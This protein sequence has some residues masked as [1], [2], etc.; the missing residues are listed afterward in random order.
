M[1]KAEV[2]AGKTLT[3]SLFDLRYVKR[4]LVETAFHTNQ[5]IGQRLASLLSDL[6]A[7][8][9]TLFVPQDVADTISVSFQQRLT[10]AGTLGAV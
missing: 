7:D 4:F 1:V 5:R 10:V 8:N 9:G 3:P 6:Y 2:E